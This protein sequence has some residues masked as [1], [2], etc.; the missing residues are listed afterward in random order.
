[1]V[2]FLTCDFHPIVLR[3]HWEVW[4][5][6]SQWFLPRKILKSEAQGMAKI[7]YAERLIDN[8]SIHA[9]FTERHKQIVLFTPSPSGRAKA[10]DNL[11]GDNLLPIFSSWRFLPAPPAVS[12]WCHFALCQMQWPND[13]IIFSQSQML[14]DYPISVEEKSL[15]K[16]TFPSI[17][18]GWCMNSNIHFN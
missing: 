6:S 5:Y 3:Y 8:V 2:W 11:S 9:S 17:P 12:K 16:S 1:M 10:G 14:M 15:E 7:M 13:V 18:G 4:E